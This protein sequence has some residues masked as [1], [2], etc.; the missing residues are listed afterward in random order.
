M[1]G[2]RLSC[3]ASK[4]LTRSLWEGNGKER[5]ERGVGPDRTGPDWIGLEWNGRYSVRLAFRGGK[6]HPRVGY[7]CGFCNWSVR[8]VMGGLPSD[9]CIHPCL[10]GAVESRLSLRVSELLY[11]C[12]IWFNLRYL[13]LMM[14]R[15]C[16]RGI[17]SPSCL[18]QISEQ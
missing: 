15:C 10:F 3:F 2:V 4:Y 12:R 18:L 17:R 16:A 14:T 6:Q 13:T 7:R 8:T 1:R 11:G 9:S 5:K